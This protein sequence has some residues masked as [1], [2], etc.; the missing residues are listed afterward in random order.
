MSIDGAMHVDA[1]SV[2]RTRGDEVLSGGTSDWG[3]A[4]ILRDGALEPLP[5]F[6]GAVVGSLGEF[7]G[8]VAAEPAPGEL[9]WT[10]FTVRG[11]GVYA[12]SLDEA[13]LV[14][15]EG[16]PA[17]TSALAHGNLIR[18]GEVLA[19]FVEHE[20]HT[21][22]GR[23]ELIGGEMVLGPR[24]L[25]WMSRLRAHVARG[26]SVVLCGGPSI[27][28][29]L[30]SRVL[31]AE[32]CDAGQVRELS[33]DSPATE[34]ELREGGLDQARVF[35]VRHLDRLPRTVQPEL[36]RL[37]RRT[38]NGMM[39]ATV[40]GEW[41]DVMIDGAIAPSMAALVAGRELQ[42]PGLDDRREDLPA[43]TQMVAARMGLPI[44]AITTG[45]LEQVVRGGWPGGV[46]EIERVLGASLV[47]GGE[48]GLGLLRR[49]VPRSRARFAL[50][51]QEADPDLARSRLQHALDR[52]S[53]TV[54][55]AARELRM[56]RQSLY[57]EIRRLGLSLP[58]QSL[59]SDTMP[60]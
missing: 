18:M 40:R 55:S 56:S 33:G 30:L 9:G 48:A 13:C 3:L 7:S 60:T 31:A 5:L 45:V 10:R 22:H 52:S 11:D 16:M 23:H 59:A 19:I 39:I 54:A 47:S 38:R 2:V 50:T 8:V 24:Q 57:R 49:S 21:Y 58:H 17:R 36:V 25:A 1:G 53:G 32:C 51:I 15:V 27:G 6:D 46:E 37:V 12:E 29:S 43:L 26:E 14:H 41:G 34:A 20:L 44:E 4:R 28:K 42:V 35:I